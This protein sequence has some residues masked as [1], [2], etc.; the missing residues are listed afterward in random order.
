MRQHNVSGFPVTEDGSAVMRADGRRGGGKVLGI[1]TR[2]D[3]KFVEDFST[4]VSK[5]MTGQ[6]LITAPPGTTLEQAEV[7]LNKNKVEKLILVDG[8]F[9]LAG[10][11]TMRDIERLSQ[12]RSC[13]GDRRI[14]AAGGVRNS[15]D[16]VALKRAGIA[17]ALVASALHDGTLTAAEMSG[18]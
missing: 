16:L 4:P 2:R 10:L 17:G 12:I 7:V 11:I 8:N 9:H 18:V 5:V 6:S 15:D 3:L 14:Y 13:A 1:I